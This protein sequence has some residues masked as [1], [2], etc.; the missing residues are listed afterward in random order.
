M[1]CVGVS[2]TNKLFG[3]GENGKQDKEAFIGNP[4]LLPYQRWLASLVFCWFLNK[5]IF[6]PLRYI[7]KKTGRKYTETF[8]RDGEIATNL[9][10]SYAFSISTL[11][12][13]I[14]Y[15][16]CNQCI[17]N[18][19]FSLK[20]LNFQNFSGSSDLCFSYWTLYSNIA[21]KR[22]IYMREVTLLDKS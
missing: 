15:Y 4:Q 18:K 3:G 5:W 8:S 6:I 16:I 1:Q 20:S 7:E 9:I 21:I 11:S 13:V 17:R 22:K 14:T 19:Y 10:F 12:T 2:P